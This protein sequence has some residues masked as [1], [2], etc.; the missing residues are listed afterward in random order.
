MVSVFLTSR[1]P[2]LSGSG[3]FLYHFQSFIGTT[4]KFCFTILIQYLPAHKWTYRLCF[5]TLIQYPFT[6]TASR[7]CFRILIHHPFIVQHQDQPFTGAA[8][9]STIHRCGININHSQVRHQYQPFT[10]AASISTIHRCGLKS[11]P[12]NKTAA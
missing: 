10:G 2:E 11:A 7:C 4:S 8:S 6:G 9:R 1:N 12:V 3:F 5:K